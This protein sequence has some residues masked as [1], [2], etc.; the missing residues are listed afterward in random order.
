MNPIVI[1][2]LLS[3]IAAAAVIILWCD[4]I[5]EIMLNRKLVYF[6]DR[7]NIFTDK[8]AME[9]LRNSEKV[10]EAQKWFDEAEKITLKGKAGEAGETV[11]YE[12]LQKEKSDKWALLVH[13][14]ANVPRGISHIAKKYYENGYNLLMPCLHGQGEDRHRYV[15]M[16]YYDKFVVKHWCEHI[17]EKYPGAQIALHGVSMGGATVLLA[18]GEELPENVKVCVSDCAYA[19]SKGVFDGFMR[20]FAFFMTDPI[21]HMVNLISKVRK[22]FN[23]EKCKPIEAVKRSKTPTL[24]I[25]G[26]EDHFVSFDNM[27]MLYNACSAEKSKLS[28]PSSPH[29]ICSLVG[30]EDY[31][32][33]VWEFEE[34]YI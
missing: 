17:S 14:Y 19:T 31:W 3:V 1:K 12:F 8:R 21:L 13:G 11:A 18:T 2:A 23:F 33:K 20:S 32:K 22:N 15:S 30:E 16:G 28:I 5:Y 29:S 10:K 9:V 25:H 26:T 4:M 34:K 27:E 6:F 7:N 24:F